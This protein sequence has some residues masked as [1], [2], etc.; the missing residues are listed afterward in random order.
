MAYYTDLFTI[1]TYNAYL[2]SD[3][4][5]SGFRE[6]QWPMAQ[7][8]K[9]GDKLLA[10]IKGI[11]RWA[12]VIRV[13]EGPFIDKTP[14]FVPGNDPFQVRFR[15]EP[16]PCLPL[17]HAIPIREEAVFNTLSF[18]KG[19]AGGYW[20]GPLRRSLQH[21]DDADGE[22]LE[23]LIVRQSKQ[24][25]AYPLDPSELDKASIKTIKR[26]DGAVSVSV[27]IDDVEDD[28]KPGKSSRE[29]IR[30]QAN[31]ARLGEAMGFS[32]WLPNND[33]AAVMEHWHPED[34]R[35]IGSLPLNYD[36]LTLKTIEQIDVLWLKGRAIQ[37]AFEV[38]HTTSIY[39]GLLRMADLLALQPN[40]NIKLHIVAPAARREKVL[41]EIRRPVFSLIEH[42]PLSQRCSYLAYED[43][44]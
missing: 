41:S 23:R 10:Y 8:I 12:A 26:P 16:S 17:E 21:I 9:P 1:E 37:R 28:A 6:S 19:R 7:K 22:F 33:R 29:S 4:C 30:I 25:I 32:I 43:L 24:P 13:V 18:T 11:S 36:D 20:L 3:Q 2:N 40:M 34:G 31:L 39:S 15:V 27:P 5:I 42:Q 35:L 14:I 44:N 38:E